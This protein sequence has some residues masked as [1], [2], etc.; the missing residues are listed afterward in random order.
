[1][2]EIYDHIGDS[3]NAA[4]S[5]LILLWHFTERHCDWMNMK[6]KQ[7]NNFLKVLNSIG[8]VSEMI[9]EYH[10]AQQRKTWATTILGDL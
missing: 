6:S 1:M 8:R 2:L 5:L 10:F 7:H 3:V 4:N 9:N